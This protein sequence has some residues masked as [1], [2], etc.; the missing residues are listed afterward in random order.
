MTP[1]PQASTEA[2][3]VASSPASTLQR[4]T[5]AMMRLCSRLAHKSEI[6]T[7]LFQSFRRLFFESAHPNLISTVRP[8]LANGVLLIVQNNVLH[9]SR[10]AGIWE[11]T[12]DLIA[13]VACAQH[14]ALSL[15][16]L[17]H[18]VLHS[19]PFSERSL[20]SCLG[21]LRVLLLDSGP[22][23]QEVQSSAL[24]LAITLHRMLCEQQAAHDSTAWP[25]L[26]EE[27]LRLVSDACW[28]GVLAECVSVEAIRALP[29]IILLGGSS[30]LALNPAQLMSLLKSAL[31]PTLHQLQASAVGRARM[32]AGLDSLQRALV[33]ALPEIVHL[34]KFELVWRSSLLVL[35][36]FSRLDS[37]LDDEVCACAVWLVWWLGVVC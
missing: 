5:T 11:L 13:L 21:T 16:A 12:V 34:D 9:L 25:V 3:L 27:V 4:S 6:A 23:D 18:L 7:E 36:G 29:S 22:L 20:C 1:P 14:A 30:P 28:S 15:A 19:P 8:Q 2:L 37:S 10:T 32:V 35:A 17:E 31:L 33:H 24:Q 26:A